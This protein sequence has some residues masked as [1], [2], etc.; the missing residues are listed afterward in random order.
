MEKNRRLKT[1]CVLSTF[2]F[3]SCTGTKNNT[4]NPVSSTSSQVV[5]EVG[6]EKILYTELKENFEAGNLNQ[7]YSLDELKDFLPIYLDYRAKILSAKEDGYFEDERILSEYELYSKQAA[8]S[9]WIENKIR[10]TLFEEFKSKNSVELKS[11]HLLIALERNAKPAD[12]LQA[13][14]KLIEARD[15]FLSGTSTMAELDP[16]YSSSQNG[17]SMGGDL[18]W[19]SVGTT[20]K[21]FE[22]VLFDLEKG[23]ISMPFK[24]QFGYHVVFLEDKREKVPAREISHIFVSPTK[25]PFS[26]DSAYSKLTKGLSWSEA[27]LQYTQDKPSAN[28]A[29]K[30]GWIGTGGRYNPDF[31]D[32]VMSLDPSLPFSKPIKTSYG[33][34]IFKVDSIRAFQN[35]AAKDKYLMEQLEASRSFRKSN[36]FIITWLEEY[37]SSNQNDD[38]LEIIR[39]DFLGKDSTLV[40]DLMLSEE[41]LSAEVFNFKGESFSSKEYLDFLKR[42]GKG[43]LAKNYSKLWFSDFK[44][45]IID[46]KLVS[47][48]LEEFP[49]FSYQTE[50][51]KSGLVVYQVNEDSVWSSAT[52][53]TTKLVQMYESKPT[54]YMFDTRYFYHLITSSRDS[55]LQKAISFVNAGNSP[56]S[57]RSNG[58]SVGVVSDSTGSFQGE[59]FD[60]LSKMEIGTFSEVFDYSNRKAVFYLNSILPKRPMTF[61]ESFNRLVSEY[62]P[63]REERW[64]NR[65]RNDFNIKAHFENLEQAY[66]KDHSTE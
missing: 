62:Q 22:D 10:P 37:Y 51:Y 9:Y 6:Y 59:P 61:E 46:S 66:N 1:L 42:T 60:K 52:L 3:I 26:I 7:E 27:V 53:D 36:S 43:P 63:V 48:T 44:T 13:Y 16:E 28:N 45:D 23:E 30:I 21:E 31:I 20:V 11:S 49:E 32:T 54:E 19:F 14:N 12:T 39:M 55:S 38:L 29:G 17:R 18:P 64:L 41:I 8:Y 56:D 57:I 5:G 34:H 50:N 2:V 35:E 47:L 15:K 4:T 25:Y 65:I 24:T 40:S 58:I 33:L